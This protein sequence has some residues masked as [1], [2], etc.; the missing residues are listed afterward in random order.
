MAVRTKGEIKTS[1]K[2]A[3]NAA[4]PQIRVDVN[5]GPFFYLCMEAVSQPLADASAESERIAQLST[6]QFP[7]SATDAEAL[8]LARAF[9]L[10]LGRG[11]YAQGVAYVYTGRRPSGTQTLAV[12]N[13]DTF[14]TAEVGGQIFEAIESKVLTEANADLFY[15]QANRRYEL[16]V[17][18]QALQAGVG[19][20]IAAQ[21]LNTINGGAPDFDG[22]TNLEPFSGGSS[23]ETVD[24]LYDRVRQ[25]LQGIDNF[26]R[27][28]LQSRAQNIDTDRVLATAL[29][30]SSEYPEL[31]YRLP[32]KQA[33]DLWVYGTVQSTQVTETFVG[34]AGQTVFTLGK[35]PAIG[36]VSV[37]VNGATAS[38][39]LTLDTSLE[40]GGSTAEASTV[41]VSSPAIA[42]G[43]IIDIT[44]TYDNVLNAIQS[45]L[46]GYLN[47][48][49]GALFGAD[50]LVRKSKTIDVS[51]SITGSVL[52]TFDPT[53]IEDQ[54]A[55]VTSSYITNGVAD[56]PALGGI[57]SPSELRD[58]IRA[59]VPGISVVDI[60]EFSR[61]SVAPLVETIDIPRHSRLQFAL[62]DD[63]VVNFT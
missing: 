18:V 49:A 37:E 50:V 9:G 46:D 22:V 17:L 43:D 45:D 56:S 27:G 41:T 20:N 19:A 14:S 60:K 33:I 47:G 2:A 58:I 38:G 48:D 3:I 42:T 21:T 57:R 5:K 4:S 29:T 62:A 59:N 35:G 55:S 31:F 12:L 15:N 36:L 23:S 28:G 30:Y 25:R 24:A 26:S 34:S 1:M 13:G 51:V 44:Y 7:T 63:L 32:D 52:G 53:S 39:L 6:L 54:I 10:S 8:A 61:K 40:V 11:G 16:P